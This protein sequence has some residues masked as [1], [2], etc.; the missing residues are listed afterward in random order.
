MLP[1]RKYLEDLIA[2]GDTA[3]A[4]EELIEASS[5]SNRRQHFIELYS[6]F[7]TLKD[8]HRIGIITLDE[9]MR[10]RSKVNKSLLEFIEDAEK[11]FDFKSV[12]VNISDPF[13]ES[14][15]FSFHKKMLPIVA[16]KMRKEQ[17]FYRQ[18]MLVLLV[19][20]LVVF[21]AG[22]YF[23]NSFFN[24]GGW[25]L[26]SFSALPVWFKFKAG[27]QLLFLEG[28]YQTLSTSPPTGGEAEAVSS[29]LMSLV[30]KNLKL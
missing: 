14:D 5:G 13:S 2:E 19:S 9:F 22:L 7:S 15:P 27:Q 23:Q 25:T 8:H 24:I 17:S 28:L 21:L 12:G 20:S 18:C 16:S 11:K 1:D 3:K 30:Q 4:L 6:Q 26:S 29:T 10:G